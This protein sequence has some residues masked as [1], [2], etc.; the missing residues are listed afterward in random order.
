MTR[1]L[2]ALTIIVLSA[3]PLAVE[4]I[5]SVANLE[6]RNELAVIGLIVGLVIFLIPTRRDLA[7]AGRGF[8]LLFGTAGGQYMGIVILGAAAV[9]VAVLIAG[10]KS[11]VVLYLQIAVMAIVW[12]AG[13]RWVIS[14]ALG[15]D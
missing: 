6:W 14:R 9:A 2:V 1:F 3:A 8:R 11:E 12:A 10:D 7:S 5:T 13:A 4:K 15:R